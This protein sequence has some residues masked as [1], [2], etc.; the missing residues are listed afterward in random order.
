MRTG[1][2][3]RE[4]SVI[5]AQLRAQREAERLEEERKVRTSFVRYIDRRLYRRHAA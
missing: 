5:L 1:Y 4:G 3:I 2:N